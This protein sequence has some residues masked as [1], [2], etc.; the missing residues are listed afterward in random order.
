MMHIFQN[1]S[2]RY[3]LG[4][5][6]FAI[7]F[8]TCSQSASA[9]PQ[10]DSQTLPLSPSNWA[11]YQALDPQ[12]AYRGADLGFQVPSLAS[13]QQGKASVAMWAGVGGYAPLGTPS[14]VV[15]T[16]V[17]FSIDSSGHQTSSAFW[18]LI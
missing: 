14:E 2:R 12:S 8:M 6:L 17:I 16:G 5:A 11:G 10:R 9:T 15:Q 4:C 7:F 18:E 13:P 1:A 3:L